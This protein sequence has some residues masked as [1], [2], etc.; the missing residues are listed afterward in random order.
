MLKQQRA[1]ALLIYS[2][3][4]FRLAWREGRGEQG[5]SNSTIEESFNPFL[6]VVVV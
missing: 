2:A 1:R 5:P 3:N 4:T 6:F